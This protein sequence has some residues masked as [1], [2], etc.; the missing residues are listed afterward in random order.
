MV[1]KRGKKP[2]WSTNPK[3][4]EQIEGLYA[5][6][7]NDRRIK[8]YY[9]KDKNGKQITCG[10]D[11]F[12]A[13]QKYSTYLKENNIFIAAPIIRDL[14]LTL[15]EENTAN[16]DEFANGVIAT[17]EN[18]SKG[19]V[20]IESLDISDEFWQM[21]ETIIKSNMPYAGRRLNIPEL[22][23]I[24]D[25][26]PPVKS[27]T[28]DELWDI[29]IKNYEGRSN[30][31][32]K[33]NIRP[34]WNEFKKCIG[35][36]SVRI[37]EFGDISKYNDKVRQDKNRPTVE[38]QYRYVKNRFDAVKG[39][40]K[41]ATDKI[42]VKDDCN[43]LLK[44][45]EQLTYVKKEQEEIMLL[46]RPNYVLT[47]KELTKLIKVSEDDLVVKCSI[48]LGLN[49]CIRWGDFAKM[50][51][52]MLDFER[53][54]YRSWRGK[55]AK[56]Q[57]CKLWD[58][59]IEVLQLY[60]QQYPTDNDYVFLTSR[61]NTW[62]KKYL[63]KNFN[64]VRKIAGMEWLTHEKLRKMTATKSSQLG[65][66]STSNAYKALMGRKIPGADSSYIYR[67]PADTEPLINELHKYYFV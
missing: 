35:K 25:I 22:A 40:I 46:Q 34:A 49:C 8:T 5:T 4:G 36:Q 32:I 44:H 47:A 14:T 54:E 39:V 31:N 57:A 23:Y 27:V 56:S 16:P 67:M 21:A 58:E 15:T 29:Y 41:K 55:N 17:L 53:K 66:G 12:R 10:S 7:Y 30:D 65:F 51:K 2:D 59:S 28:L 26:T 61:K 37:I 45:M 1:R 43:K 64:E 33:N 62:R 6:Y 19:N 9:Y 52:S 38:N 13:D 48:L 50:T 63:H 3:T 18:L 20:Q 24:T 11:F 60:M 42:E